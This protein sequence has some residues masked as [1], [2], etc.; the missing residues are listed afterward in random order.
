ML[1]WSDI[2]LTIALD[3]NRS[4]PSQDSDSDPSSTTSTS[5][6]SHDDSKQASITVLD[7]VSGFAKP[8]RLLAVMGSSGWVLFFMFN[9]VAAN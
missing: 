8:G 1:S 4:L 5:S 7:G 3:L 6:S 9:T 2:T